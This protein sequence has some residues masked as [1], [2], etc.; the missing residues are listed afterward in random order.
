MKIETEEKDGKLYVTVTIPTYHGGNKRM[1]V[2][3]RLL[4]E[5]LEK[6]KIK[7]GQCLHSVKVTNRTPDRCRGTF[8]FEL[9]KPK[10]KPKP[11][12]KPKPKSRKPT[13]STSRKVKKKLDSD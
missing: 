4:L 12:P 5:T 7:H 10:S 1:K 11:K 8:I 13:T 2:D 9:L 6:K 3:L